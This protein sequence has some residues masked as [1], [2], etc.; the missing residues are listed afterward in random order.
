MFLLFALACGGGSDDSSAPTDTGWYF[1]PYESTY[2]DVGDACLSR[3]NGGGVLADQPGE[4]R[5]EFDCVGCG[6]ATLTSSCTATL[7]GTELQITAQALVEVSG[8]PPSTTCTCGYVETTCAAPALPAGA[9]TIVYGE[10]QGAV[11]VPAP[12]PVCVSGD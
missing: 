5:V 10:G 4:I 8:T 9:Y 1:T 12:S 6:V 7:V 11:D 2:T 3:D